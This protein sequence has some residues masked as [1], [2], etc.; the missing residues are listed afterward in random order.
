MVFTTIQAN[1]IAKNALDLLKLGVGYE[2]S[3]SVIDVLVEILNK[4]KVGGYKKMKIK[5]KK[6]KGG[7]KPQEV[8]MLEQAAVKLLK[9]AMVYD[10]ST[11]ILTQIQKILNKNGVKV[12]KEKK[13]KK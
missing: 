7:M 8:K 4:N 9:V 10:L 3:K 12:E 11:M 6:M 2:L 13:E 1:K 5:A